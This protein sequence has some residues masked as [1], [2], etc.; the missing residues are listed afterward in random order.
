MPHII[1]EYSDQ[2]SLD[3]TALLTELHDGLTED[4]SVDKARIKTRAI[5][6]Q[7]CIVGEE[8]VPDEMVHITLKLMPRPEDV[9]EKMAKNLHKIAC[10]LIHAQNPDCVVTVET[11]DIHAH[12]YCH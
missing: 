4:P 5:P 1:V 8:S 2:L 3:M 9:R 11:C 10:G 6:L 7:I 12:S